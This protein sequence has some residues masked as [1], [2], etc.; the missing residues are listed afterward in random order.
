MRAIQWLLM[1]VVAMAQPVL[2]E[3]DAASLT[4]E[5]DKTRSMIILDALRYSEGWLDVQDPPQ[6]DAE[7]RC[8]SQALYFEARGE[9]LRGQFAVAEVILNR[10][11]SARFPDTVCQVVAQGASNL[12][13]CQFS[14]MCDGKPETISEEDAWAEVGKV[15]AAALRTGGG[16]LTE[17]ATHY[18]TTAVAPH[19]SRVYDQTAQIGDHLF[20]RHDWE[21]SRR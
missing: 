19:W 16:T 2:A 7:W 11:D 18:H 1:A 10:V 15:A 9:P 4:Q 21:A 5:R 13:R 6:G 14:Y 3:T 8:L 20:Y 12:H 17:G